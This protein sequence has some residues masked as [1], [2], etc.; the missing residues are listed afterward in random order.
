VKVGD[1]VQ[2]THR[3]GHMAGKVGIITGIWKAS[4]SNKSK[5]YDEAYATA[6]YIQDEHGFEYVFYPRSLRVIG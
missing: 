2:V 4:K 1:L 6:F 5:S 3:H